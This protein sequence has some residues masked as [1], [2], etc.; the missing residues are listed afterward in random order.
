MGGT[1]GSIRTNI[2]KITR[3]LIYCQS[4][5]MQVGRTGNRLVGILAHTNGIKTM[6]KKVDAILVI[7]RPQNVKQLQSFLGDVNY[8]RDMW[9]RRSYVLKP[10]TDL[11]GKGR[12]LWTPIHDKAFK[13]L[14]SLL[15]QN[16]F[17]P[18]CIM[19]TVQCMDHARK[20]FRTLSII[21]TARPILA[22]SAY[23]RGSGPVTGTTFGRLPQWRAR[24]G[25]GSISQEK[26]WRNFLL[27]SHI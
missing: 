6:E 20:Q 4:F 3:K 24:S 9:P 8:Y 12:F 25:D 15:P 18:Q 16:I 1:Y 7:D 13:A 10:L 19:S 2:T 17:M 21:E 11:T 23:I 27:K 26:T 5:Q 22:A 14:A